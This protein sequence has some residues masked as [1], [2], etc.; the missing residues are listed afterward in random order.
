MK[1]FKKVAL[2]FVVLVALILVVAAFQPADFKVER[3]ATIGAPVEV[4]F[5]QVSDFH[6]WGAWSP[7]EK[8][9]PNMK[10]SY[11]GPPSG[12][13][14]ITSWVGNHEVGEGK[15]TMTEAGAN[16]LIRIK[17]E[18]LKPF[19]ATNLA[20]FNFKTDGAATTVSWSMSGQK[21]FPMKLFSLFMSCDKMIGGDFEK[22]LAAM[23]AVAEAA[24][25][26]K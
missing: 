4:V 2:A 13:G 3:S 11:E 21:N 15:M 19:A 17:L 1:I 9:D 10:K 14:S 12:A 26:K 7:W 18:F 22:G 8:L 24:T 25:S 16:A 5:A 23:K 6:N 20:E